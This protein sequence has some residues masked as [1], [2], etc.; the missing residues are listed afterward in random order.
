MPRSIK[1]SWQKGADGSGRAGRWRKKYK[2]K[3]YY[4]AGGKGKSDQEAYDAAIAAWEKLKGQIDLTTPR[5]HQRDY[6]TAIDQW[7]QVLAFCNRYG[8]REHA[9]Q[10]VEKLTDLRRRFAA[11]K[12]TPL[13]REDQFEAN[14]DL[15]ID[16]EWVRELPKLVGLVPSDGAQPRA[17]PSPPLSVAVALGLDAPGEPVV[18]TPTQ[19]QIDRLDGSPLRIARE[20][21]R[22]RLAVMKRKA[23]PEDESLQAHIQKYLK[24][25]EA[26]AE[27]SQVSTGRCYALRLHLTHF[28][29]WLGK[30]TS[31]KEIDGEV[32]INF[33]THVLGKAATKEWTKTT[34]SH[35]MTTTKSLVRWLWQSNAIPTLPRVL[36]GR[37]ET[38]KITKTKPGIV[39]FTMEEIKALL[40]DASDRTKLYILL[41][42]NCGMTQK[43]ISD[44]LVTEVDWKEGRIIRKRSK[45]SEEENVPVVNYKLWPETFRLLQQERDAKS[46][47]RV[48]VNSNGGPIWSEEITKDGKYRKTDNVKNAFDRL[49]TVKKIEEPPD[50]PKKR[51]ARKV[52]RAVK[53]TIDKPLKSLK[54]TSASLLRDNAKFSNLEK[55]FLGHAPQS[56]SDKHYAKVPQKLLD[57]AVLWLGKQYGLG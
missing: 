45:T 19:E 6:E 23:A 14:F 38:L 56:M 43:D 41:M 20:L 8:D 46:K 33:R 4:F 31:V 5:R 39:T 21:W 25:K 12:L 17:E 32:L 40:A 26:E 49:R 2:A 51:S 37:S 36:D 50:A 27:A 29:D 18:I 47:D 15:P 3:T 11:T 44:L 28:Q 10:A 13:K 22:D 57:Q 42:L 35:Y 16:A 24:Q 7:E 1:L 30:D 53:A 55:L 52:E 54:K 34:A 9:D 48:L